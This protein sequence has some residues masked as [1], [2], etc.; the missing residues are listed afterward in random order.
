MKLLSTKKTIVL[1]IIAL[2]VLGGIAAI[3]QGLYPVA[4]VSGSPIFASTLRT[5]Y[6]SALI[7]AANYR[8]VYDPGNTSDAMRPE[9]IEAQVLTN[10]INARLVEAAARAEAGS[11]LQS[12]V[13]QKV[14]DYSG[15]SAQAQSLYGMSDA[16]FKSEV[17]VPQ[18]EKDILSARLFLRGG[19]ADDVLK[20]L[21]ARI[22]VTIFSKTFSWDGD[23]V[24]AR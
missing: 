6:A 1:L 14:N 16:Q 8:R 15:L 7:Y 5:D 12:L 22:R 9:D 11:D 4:L 3:G 20:D 2:A 24:V 19:N 17:L 21:R 18:A 13:D 10:L 23:K